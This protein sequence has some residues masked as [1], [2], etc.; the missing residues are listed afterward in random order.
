MS[1][2]ACFALNVT[3]SNLSVNTD[4]AQKACEADYLICS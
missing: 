1:V 2:H 3:A 4:L